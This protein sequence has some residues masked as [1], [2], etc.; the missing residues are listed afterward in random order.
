VGN[1][2]VGTKGRARDG[3]RKPAEGVFGVLGGGGDR[4]R[5]RG[6]RTSG[7]RGSTTPRAQR[8]RS[9]SGDTGGGGITSCLNAFSN[10]RGEEKN[11]TKTLVRRSGS[12]K[13][14]GERKAATAVWGTQIPFK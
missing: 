2:W 12:K 4:E 9:R 11:E 6:E 7:G 10:G 8:K 3:R 13:K 5:H 1:G 14:R